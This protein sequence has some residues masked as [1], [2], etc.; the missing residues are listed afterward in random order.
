MNIQEEK[1]GDAWR[2]EHT[3]YKTHGKN[4][5]VD[6]DESTEETE[7]RISQDPI[8]NIDKN[9]VIGKNEYD[10]S[11]YSGDSVCDIFENEEQNI[12]ENYIV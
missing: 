2:N 5:D 6:D 9:L 10:E 3:N 8:N 12:T 11:T 1:E 4:I 7:T